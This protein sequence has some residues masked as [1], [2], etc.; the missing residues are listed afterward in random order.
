VLSGVDL[1]GSMPLL[2]ISFNCYL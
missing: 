2:Y 1:P